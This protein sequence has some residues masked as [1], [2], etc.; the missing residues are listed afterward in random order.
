MTAPKLDSKTARFKLKPARKPYFYELEGSK[1]SLG[2]RRLRIGAGRWIL[3]RYLGERHYSLEAFAAADDEDPSNGETILTFGEAKTRAREMFEDR[4]SCDLPSGREA[5]TVAKAI[6][7]YLKGR[8]ARAV[9]RMTLHVLADQ[10]GRIAVR[11]LTSEALQDWRG[12]LRSDLA[13]T[14]RKRITNDFR[15]ALNQSHRR[16]RKS[17]PVGL[18]VVI[19]DGFH[20]E[21]TVVAV[22]RD[23]Q[24][25]ADDEIRKIIA[26]AWAID[27]ENGWD[28]DLARL[29]V[30]LAA[31]G[32][33]FSQVIRMTV[34]DVQAA[35]G[36]FMVPVSNKGKGA[37]AA[38]RIAVRVGTD[39]IEA[40]APALAR[41][42]SSAP[43]FERWF[44]V[45]ESPTEWVRDRR[46]PWVT[47]SGMTRPWALI[48]ARASVPAETVPYALRHSSIVKDLRFGL[49]VQFVA[50]KH[51][52]SAK[53]IE[54]HYAAF[55]VDA[56]DDLAARAVIP[57]TPP[58]SQRETEAA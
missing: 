4:F 17:L 49:P 24:I 56:L 13:L 18:S 11:D 53:M 35:Q 54:E 27:G 42:K 8:A 51:D 15:A 12:R 29:V 32:A 7:D 40:L 52:T 28:G 39:V 38:S 3:R 37:K 1:F 2:Y 33:R 16:H 9:S 36:R 22:A 34:A 6:E 46:G 41:R 5:L 20:S 44:H 10:I 19:R 14:S 45:Q 50:R 31:T 30:T 57:L 43:L 58:C 25:L 55:I 26:A 48:V 21:E 23:K 47:A